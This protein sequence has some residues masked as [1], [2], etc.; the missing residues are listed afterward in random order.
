MSS[1]L[2]NFSHLE[3]LRKVKEARRITGKDLSR[4]TGITEANISGFF[5]GKVNTKVST[6]DRLV[7]AMEKI[8]PGARRDYAQELAGIVSIDEGGDSLL[9]QQINDLPKESKKQ[10]I[11]AIVESLAAESKSEIRLAS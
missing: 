9:E 4:E 1:E 8:S 3:A 11:M 2:Y 6:L 7:E 10:L 5:N